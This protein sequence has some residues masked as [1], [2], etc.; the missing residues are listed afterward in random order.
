MNNKTELHLEEGEKEILIDHVYDGIQELNNPLPSWWS[1]T[2]WAGIV[3]AII[4][5]AATFLGAPTLRDE[6]A[7][8]HVKNLKLQDDFNKKNGSFESAKYMAIMK[9]DGLGQGKAVYMKNCFSC[10]KEN[11]AGGIGPNLS[12]EY[13]LYSKGTPESNFPVVF[14]GV[15]EEGMPTWSAKIS[16]KEIYQVVGY[17]Q[18]LHNTNQPEGKKPRGE[19]IVDGQN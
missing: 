8:E 18:S 19:K 2:F 5:I 15:P 17:I 12:D 14:N 9:D 1:F 10:H 6:F 7:L 11:G 13:W 3:F 4:Y 16:E